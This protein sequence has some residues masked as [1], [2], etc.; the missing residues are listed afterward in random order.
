MFTYRWRM[1]ERR[2]KID[3][4]AKAERVESQAA[5]VAARK[6]PVRVAPKPQGGNKWGSIEVTFFNKLEEDVTELSMHYRGVEFKSAAQV[7]EKRDFSG[8]FD[9]DFGADRTRTEEVAGAVIWSQAM[10][11]VEVRYTVRGYRF[12][13]RGADVSPL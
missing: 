6:C 2:D 5:L 4:R 11:H 7:N 8:D 1:V 13:R 10:P 9:F 3:A 12:K